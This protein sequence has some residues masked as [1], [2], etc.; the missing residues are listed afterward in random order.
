METEVTPLESASDELHSATPPGWFV[1]R[2]AYEPRRP[3]PWSMYA[4]D[5]TERPKVGKRSR[6]WTAVAPTEERVIR[7][8]AR[9]LREIDEGRVPK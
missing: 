7:E 1:G 5:T 2:P 4:F 9:C 3:V 8:M 6:D